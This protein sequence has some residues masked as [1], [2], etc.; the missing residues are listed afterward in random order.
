[1]FFDEFCSRFPP[2][3]LCY[4]A[5]PLCA[6]RAQRLSESTMP[7]I[8]GSSDWRTQPPP[9][10]SQQCGM[11]VRSVRSAHQGNH[12]THRWRR[13]LLPGYKKVCTQQSTTNM[14][15]ID[16]VYVPQC[17]VSAPNGYQ[18]ELTANRVAHSGLLLLFHPTVHLTSGRRST[19]R[20]VSCR[21]MSCTSNNSSI[22]HVSK[23]CCVPCEH[24]PT[25]ML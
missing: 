23:R 18:R 8:I 1:M 16:Y 6:A 3:A 15:V 11:V 24:Y 20:A 2:F 9:A 12:A 5:S 10:S 4:L 21:L 19:K 14:C 22:T 25:R 13:R 7:S 17:M